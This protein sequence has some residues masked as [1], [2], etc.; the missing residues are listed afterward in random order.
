MPA[1]RVHELSMTMQHPTVLFVITTNIVARFLQ[2]HHSR[3]H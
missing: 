1:N 2:D 3:E